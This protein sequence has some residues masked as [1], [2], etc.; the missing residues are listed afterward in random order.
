[1][2]ND[3]E[4]NGVVVQDQVWSVYLQGL[5]N[6][7]YD[8]QDRIEV[9]QTAIALPEALVTTAEPPKPV[10]AP[11]E[12]SNAEFQAMFFQVGELILSAPL[13]T[14]R[15]VVRYGQHTVSAVPG[16]PAW[17]L[18]LMDHRGEI[19][20]LIDPGSLLLGTEYNP[21][22]RPYRYIILPDRKGIGLVCNEF[23]DMGKVHPDEVRWCKDRSRRPWLAGVDIQRLRA[24][25]D[26]ERLLPRQSIISEK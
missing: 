13:I 1:M 2:V 23:I 12:W 4:T 16:R 22:E 15:E 5:L 20:N 26:I 14:L 21:A 6:R 11:P 8:T 25:I 24:V 17:S 18:G 9:R 19:I 7:A 3:Q 10:L